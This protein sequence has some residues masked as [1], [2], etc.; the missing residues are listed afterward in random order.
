MPL[1]KEN[2]EIK[3]LTAFLHFCPLANDI[4]YYLSI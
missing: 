3:D 2:L 4:S 1:K